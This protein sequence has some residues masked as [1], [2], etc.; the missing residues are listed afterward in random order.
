MPQ[1]HDFRPPCHIFR[2]LHLHLLV[3]FVSTDKP[4]PE[5]EGTAADG[6]GVGQDRRRA[7][8]RGWRRA[9]RAFHRSSVRGCSCRL[10]LNG[11]TGGER[12]EDREKARRRWRAVKGW[13][14]GEAAMASSSVIVDEL[15][16]QICAPPRPCSPATATPAPVPLH[17]LPATILADSR[18]VLSPLAN[19]SSSSP[20]ALSPSSRLLALVGAAS[21]SPRANMREEDEN[22]DGSGMVL[23]LKVFIDTQ[24]ITRIVVLFF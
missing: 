23:I 6:E 1:L 11:Q 17:N 19:A 20:L 9:R 3:V 8:R 7:P 14:E 10:R 13:G 22:S 15:F 16:H 4:A 21:P 24:L 12:R 2:R 5:E 18:L